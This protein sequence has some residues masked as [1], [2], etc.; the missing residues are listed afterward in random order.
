MWFHLP[1]AS[2]AA[3]KHNFQWIV[4]MDCERITEDT[5]YPGDNLSQMWYGMELAA[6]PSQRKAQLQKSKT[7]VEVFN[8]QKAEILW[9]EVLFPFFFS[10]KTIFIKDGEERE[11]CFVWET[12]AKLEGWWEMNWGQITNRFLGYLKEAAL[13]SVADREQLNGLKKE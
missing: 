6:K 13:Y 11:C 1:W 2:N 3:Q 4:I 5:V 7:T 10:R 9:A 8:Q 12:E